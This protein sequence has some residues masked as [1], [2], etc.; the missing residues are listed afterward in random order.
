MSAIVAANRKAVTGIAAVFLASGI[1]AGAVATVAPSFTN[2]F[3]ANAAEVVN[4]ETPAIAVIVDSATASTGVF[5][6]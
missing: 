1:L 5:S 2:Q 6:K 3:A 4:G